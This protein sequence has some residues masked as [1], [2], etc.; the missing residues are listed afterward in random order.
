VDPVNRRSS[1]IV[2]GQYLT[3]PLEMFTSI[4]YGPP[5]DSP[6]CGITWKTCTGEW[7]DTDRPYDVI[8]KGYH[9]W[10]VRGRTYVMLVRFIPLQG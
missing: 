1:M 10:P 5:T 7:W 4:V 3:I 2:V 9:T 6:V 8:V